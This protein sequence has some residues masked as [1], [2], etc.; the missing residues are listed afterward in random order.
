MYRGLVSVW[1]L[2][3]KVIKYVVLVEYYEI[4]A[5][6]ENADTDVIS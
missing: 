3:E 6:Q 1:L 4:K 5:A 2:R